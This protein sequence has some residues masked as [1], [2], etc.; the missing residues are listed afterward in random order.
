M[1]C[2]LPVHFEARVRVCRE[3]Q[4]HSKVSTCQFFVAV[5][6]IICS[7]IKTDRCERSNE[8]LVCVKDAEFVD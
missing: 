1:Y 4:S 8:L 7:D 5:S 3:L 6:F 2:P